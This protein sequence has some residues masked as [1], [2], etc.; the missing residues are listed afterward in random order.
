VHGW[1]RLADPDGWVPD[2]CPAGFQQLEPQPH[3]HTG[4]PDREMASLDLWGQVRV[5][6]LQTFGAQGRMT[7]AQKFRA[8]E[9]EALKVERGAA[10]QPDAWKQTVE[11]RQLA[12]SSPFAQGLLS[13]CHRDVVLAA[14]DKAIRSAL[15]PSLCAMIRAPDEVGLTRGNVAEL[16]T[17][18][19]LIIDNALPHNVVE[20]CRLEAE[21]LDAKGYLRPPAMH[22][23][24]G[25][26]RDRLVGIEEKSELL[27][28]GGHLVRLIQYLKSLAAELI[29]GGYNEALTVPPSIMLACYDGQ[30]AF[31]KPH[32]D[33]MDDDPRL[34]TAIFYLVDDKWDG[35]LEADGGNLIWWT[36]TED[37]LESAHSERE[38]HQLE[39][40]VETRRS[41]FHLAVVLCCFLSCAQA[42]RLVVFNSRTVMHE[43]MPTHRKRFAVTL[44]FFRGAT[45]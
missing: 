27:V 20:G 1:Q 24:L 39:P 37:D 9:E 17:N 12:Q 2:H 29:D 26:R 11:Q 8:W 44:W 25:D 15:S 7:L 32:M 31:Y 3:V 35:R 41:S 14:Q 19:L 43:V 5:A 10:M 6:V 28:P 23:A 40:K 36:V 45:P 16:Q 34:V 13:V 42:G 18:H 33:S 4:R 38:K 22:R 30:G 21:A